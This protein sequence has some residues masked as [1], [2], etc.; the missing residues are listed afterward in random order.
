[1][2]SQLVHQYTVSSDGT[3]IDGDYI[4]SEHEYH[5]TE[6]SVAAGIATVRPVRKRYLFRTKRKTPKIGLMIVGLGGNNGTTVTAGV[7]ANREKISWDTKRGPMQANFYG[8]LTQATTIRLGADA[9]G[10]DVYIPFSCILPMVHPNDLVISG[11]DI[12][13]MNMADA[14]HR[15]AVL[16]YDLQRQLDPLMRPMKP[17]PSIYIPDFIAANQS[18]R[19]DNVLTG[20]IYAQ[21]EQIRQHIREFKQKNQLDT[22]VVLWSA[23]TE[24]FSEIT[25]GVHDTGD[26]LLAALKAGHPEISPSTVFAIA[27]ILEGSPY[28]NGSPQNAIVPGVVDLAIRHAVPVGGDDF[29]S[30][31][32]KFKSVLTD[33]LVQAGLKPMSIASYNHLGNNDGKNLS[34]PQQFRSKE[35][36]KSTVVDDIVGSNAILYKPN[37]HPDHTIVIKYMPYVGDSKRALD[38][39]ISEIFMGGQNTIVVHNTCEDSLLAAPLI[40]DLAILAELTTRIEFKTD[41]MAD[42]AHFHPVMSVLSYMLKS[43]VVPPQT[44]VVNALFKQRSCLENIL[45]VCAGLPV[46]HNMLLEHK[47]FENLP[48]TAAKTSKVVANGFH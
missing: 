2:A 10:Q 20:P 40:L 30:G 15:A 22:V 33:F 24:R 36:T 25:A 13:G 6:V 26:N 37:E 8:S 18:D 34:A 19:A 16:D 23:T 41:D 7:I 29:K 47:C 43:P 42:F 46:E 5:N 28:I 48:A 11:W 31:Q 3:R 44:P 21:M 27:S 45:R 32:T 9:S 39:Y 1:M 38:E 14:M 17:L 4:V 12:S 35:I